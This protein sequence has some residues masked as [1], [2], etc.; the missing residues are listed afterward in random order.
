MINRRDFLKMSALA[1][2]GLTGFSDVFAQSDAIRFASANP[3]SGPFAA[4][5]KFADLGMRLAIE[6][7]GKV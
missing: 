2:P 1:A 4:N 5:G 6:T 3:M 7:Y